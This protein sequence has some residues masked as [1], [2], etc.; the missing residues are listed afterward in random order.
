MKKSFT[1]EERA[2]MEFVNQ[3]KIYRNELLK[4]LIAECGIDLKDLV[5]SLDIC[6]KTFRRY[7]N[8]ER[9]LPMDTYFKACYFLTNHMKEN[10]IPYTKR[11]QELISLTSLFTD[12][13]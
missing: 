1:N 4:E 3:H 11:I 7:L 12:F 6:Y 2:E 13:V 9:K 8:Y 10:N 5:V